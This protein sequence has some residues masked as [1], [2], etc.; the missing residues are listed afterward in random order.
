MANT[1]FYGDNLQVMRMQLAD[2]SVDLVYLDPPFNSKASYN[3]L[4]KSPT[5]DRSAAQIEAFEDTW[6]WTDDAESAFDEV[7]HSG[8]GQAAEMLRAF[9]SFLKENDLMAYLTMMAVRMLELHRVL[10]ATGSLYL[11]CDPTASHYLKILLDAV[12]GADG[13]RNEII[14]KRTSA[15]S[16]AK[17]WGPVSDSLLF[18]SKTARFTWNPVFESYA[19][20][21][22]DSHYRACDSD[23]QFQ[24][25][26]L[27]GAGT[28]QGDSGRP[29]RGIDPTKGGRHWAVPNKLCRKVASG[30]DISTLSTQKKL[31]LLDAAGL[32]HFSSRGGMPRYKRHIGATPGTPAT[33]VWTDIAPLNSQAQERL[34]Y[35]TQKPVAL[36]ERIIEA[37]SNPGDVILDPFCG[38]GTTI[39][40][41]QRLDRHWI[42]ID[43]TH[44]A[45]SVIERRLRDAFPQV[46]FEV[47]GTP[48]DLDGAKA[49]AAADKYQFQWWAVSLIRAVPYGDKKKGADFGI[50]GWIY[51]RSSKLVMEKGV[52]SVKGGHKVDASMIRD[53]KGVMVREKAAVGIFI[54]LTD[55]TRP[56]LKEAA[57]AG[58]Y[59]NDYGQCPSIQIYTIEQ[60]LA[61]AK[62][63]VPLMDTDAAYRKIRKEPSHPA[64]QRD[65]GLVPAWHSTT[66]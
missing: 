14:W 24:L 35:P 42:G 58:V 33:S 61:G 63:D 3:V 20:T 8:S 41:A 2:K 34:G 4:F 36:M 48:Q 64:M 55:P 43:I 30:T 18:Y 47:H 1:L 21:Y 6:H 16:S 13:F 65:L 27:T 25:V 66:T 17:R 46:V 11:H 37:S 45:I 7:M 10:K 50:D 40:A 51:F 44:L 26:C 22:V 15:H 9:R 31:E 56:M 59:H 38:C 23:G 62:V 19:A 57:A 53:L 32:I 29:W 5:G 52:V 49:L 39:H 60:L 54:T 28:R 12:F